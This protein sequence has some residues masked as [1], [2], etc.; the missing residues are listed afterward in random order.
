M[1]P[2]AIDDT[3]AAAKLTELGLLL[4]T[5]RAFPNLVAMMAGGPVKGT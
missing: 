1:S 3:Q 2:P 4:E 5:D